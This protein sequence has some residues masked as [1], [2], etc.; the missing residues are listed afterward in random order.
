MLLLFT[1]V[2]PYWILIQHFND[3]ISFLQCNIYSAVDVVARMNSN[4]R[5][6]DLSTFLF[7]VCTVTESPLRCI[8]FLKQAHPVTSS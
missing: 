5:V 7:A 8:L 1:C 3:F 2:Y 4:N 6:Q